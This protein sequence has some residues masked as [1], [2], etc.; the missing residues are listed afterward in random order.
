MTVG[1][2]FKR[3][4]SSFGDHRGPRRGQEIWSFRLST[5]FQLRMDIEFGFGA[6][7]ILVHIGNVA[8]VIA[9]KHSS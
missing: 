5:L 9:L 8:S 4:T 2:A 7:A 3:D 1:G 6:D